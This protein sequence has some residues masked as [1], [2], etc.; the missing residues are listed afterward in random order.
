MTRSPFLPLLLLAAASA[1]A[2]P[3]AGGARMGV[4]AVDP[5]GRSIRVLL[6]EAPLITVGAAGKQ[7]LQLRDQTGRLLLKLDPGSQVQVRRLG[8]SLSLQ[9]LIK[10][11][12]P[13]AAVPIP[14]LTSNPPTAVGEAPPENQGSA[15]PRPLPLQELRL[16]PIHPQDVLVL[17]QRRYR[18]SLLLRPEGAGFQAI[19]RLPLESYLMGVVGSEMPSSWPLSALR[20]QAVASRTYALQQLRPKAPFDLKATVTSQVYKGVEAESSPVRQAVVSTRGQVLLHGQQL[21]NAVF[22]SSSGGMTENSGEL[23]SRQLPYLVS[24]PDFDASSPVSHWQKAFA[25]EE[26]RQAFG[27]IGGANAIEPLQTSKTGRIRRARV[28]GPGGELVLSGAE[29]RERLGLRSTMVSFVFEAAGDQPSTAPPD[30]MEAALAA[31]SPLAAGQPAPSYRLTVKGR[32]YGHGVGLSQW[33]AYALAL[34]GKSH[35]EILRHYYRGAILR[36]SY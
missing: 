24:V 9:P 10:G 31:P 30:G 28:I 22:H 29:L 6:L 23:W 32:G 12:E 27:E 2:V 35:E 19:N 7:G 1:A 8:S 11:G 25:P 36:S 13:Q 34:R 15:L 16:E 4:G 17:K 33:G 21:I 20:A 18:G 5:H 14:L 26:L 3:L